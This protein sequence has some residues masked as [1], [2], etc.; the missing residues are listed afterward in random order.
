MYSK[1]IA[2][3]RNCNSYSEHFDIAVGSKQGE[4]MSPIVF[5][6][7]VDDLELYLKY[8]TLCGLT[9]DDITFLL[10]LFADYMVIFGKT[11]RFT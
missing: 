6:L 3:V 8:N 10:M 4:I 1:V 11:V 9:V 7:L 5:A 2:C